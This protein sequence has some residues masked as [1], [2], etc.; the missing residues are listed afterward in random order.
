MKRLFLLSVILGVLSGCAKSSN[1]SNSASSGTPT[2]AQLLEAFGWY[3]GNQMD[4]GEIGLSSTEIES[5]LR[6]VRS[7]AS[8]ESATFNLDEIGPAIEALLSEKQDAHD[9]QRR[10]ANTAAGQAFFAKLDQQE[11]VIAL[12]SGLRYEVLQ[13]GSGTA[14]TAT[15]T[16]RVNYEGRF[17]DGTVFDSSYERGEPAEFPLNG[18][19]RAW[20]EGLQLVRPGGKI[21]LYVPSAMGYGDTARPGMPPASTLIFDVELLAVNPPAAQ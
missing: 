7:A 12:P 1:D 6:G 19:I 13:A 9:E 17:I 16:V 15:D 18:V 3:L 4:L 14:P 20:T 5:V 2:D 11:N 8:G 10:L 21:R